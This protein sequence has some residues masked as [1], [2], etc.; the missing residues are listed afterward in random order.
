M[1]EIEQIVDGLKKIKTKYWRTGE[2]DQYLIQN[3]IT[4]SENSFLELFKI[5]LNENEIKFEAV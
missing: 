4:L 3:D 2:L 5:L 1:S